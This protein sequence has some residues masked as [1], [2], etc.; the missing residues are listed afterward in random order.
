M[1]IYN[2]RRLLLL[3]LSA[4]V[5]IAVALTDNKGHMHLIQY[6]LNR[7]ATRWNSAKDAD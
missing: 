2:L 1:Y 6:N 3:C 5:L 4:F 7:N